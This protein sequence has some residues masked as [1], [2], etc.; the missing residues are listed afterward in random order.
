MLIG[1]GGKVPVYRTNIGQRK[2]IPA[3]LNIDAEINGITPEFL[4]GDD[5]FI[6][7]AGVDQ[8]FTDFSKGTGNP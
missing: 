3:F 1:P 6:K 2:N 5:G 8:P 4:Q 7:K